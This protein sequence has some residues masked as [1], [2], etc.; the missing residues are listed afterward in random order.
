MAHYNGNDA[1]IT[2]GGVNV[3]PYFMELSIEETVNDVDVTAGSGADY[4]EHAP[5]LRRITMNLKLEY[6]SAQLGTYIQK[7]KPG[8][9][10]VAAY[11]EGN[12]TGKPVHTQNMLLTSTAIATVVA[13]EHVVFETQW[14]GNG[15][16]TFNILDGDVV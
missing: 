14:V 11:P 1:Y 12:S 2:I 15:T 10:D 9:H 6:E 7:L 8:S 16:P 4:E 3:S 13:K 5:G